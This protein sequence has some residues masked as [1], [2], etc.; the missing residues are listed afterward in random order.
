LAYASAPSEA[1]RSTP[2]SKVASGPENP[3]ADIAVSGT[4]AAGV[5]VPPATLPSGVGVGVAGVG[6]G[7]A[8]V[9]V[10]VAGVG[11]GVAG[12]GVGVAG[13][14]VGVAGTSLKQKE[15]WLRPCHGGP[16]TAVP[17]SFPGACS[18]VSEV[19]PL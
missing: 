2:N 18:P 10:G 5:P 15:M 9:G 19:A 14:G 3:V 8:G 6:V 4:E 17:W 13:V 7:V 16:G 1:I 11:V 12:V